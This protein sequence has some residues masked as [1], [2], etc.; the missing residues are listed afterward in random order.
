MVE[1]IDYTTNTCNIKRAKHSIE[2]ICISSLDTYW[3]LLFWRTED[4][5]FTCIAKSID[6]PK[7]ILSNSL[8]ERFE[9]DFNE[10]LQ[11]LIDLFPRLNDLIF[12]HISESSEIIL[13]NDLLIPNLGSVIFFYSVVISAI[14]PFLSADF[15]CEREKSELN[16]V[17]T[18]TKS[19][20]DRY[21]IL[22]KDNGRLSQRICILSDFKYGLLNDVLQEIS[23]RISYLPL[24]QHFAFK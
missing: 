15:L 19:I 22:F 5:L 6:I 23:E 9:K 3:S 13:G 7:G 1:S 18:E 2:N 20:I 10:T 4:L 17:F 16:K 14:F 11:K 8:H 24:I 12:I 21:L